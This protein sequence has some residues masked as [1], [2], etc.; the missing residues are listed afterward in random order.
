VQTIALDIWTT[1]LPPNGFTAQT[2]WSGSAPLDTRVL[3][4]TAECNVPFDVTLVNATTYLVRR[5]Y[6]VALQA[7]GPVLEEPAFPGATFSSMLKGCEAAAGWRVGIGGI[8]RAPTCATSHQSS[9]CGATC[10]P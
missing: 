5:A 9:S 2:V 1:L 8:T 7:L 10:A 3:N 6:V 4:R